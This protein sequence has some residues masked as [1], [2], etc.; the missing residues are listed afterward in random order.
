MI[1]GMTQYSYEQIEHIL[2]ISR[3]IVT[4]HQFCSKYRLSNPIKTNDLFCSLNN[5]KKVNEKN[6]ALNSIL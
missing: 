4:G 1:A 2:C 5:S 6:T 3:F